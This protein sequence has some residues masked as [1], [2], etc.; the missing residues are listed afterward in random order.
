MLPTQTR[1][2][3]AD[4]GYPVDAD[5]HQMSDDGGPVGPAPARWSDPEW[6]DDADEDG[7]VLAHR[8]L[9]YLITRAR[10]GAESNSA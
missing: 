2:P 9:L 10:R 3:P 7:D 5:L 4:G 6:R 8:V 1:P